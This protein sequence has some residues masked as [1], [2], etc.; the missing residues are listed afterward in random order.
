KVKGL[1]PCGSL[2]EN[3]RRIVRVRLEEVLALGEKALDPSDEKALHDTRIAAKRL[4]YVLE[5]HVPVFGEPAGAAAKEARRL[6]DL[7]GEIHDCDELLPRVQ[8]VQRELR[9]GDVDGLLDL[10]ADADDLDP[11][12]GAKVRH[13]DAYGGLEVLAVW[14]E[15]RRT[16][17]FERFL[18]RWK[19]LQR[20]AFRERLE[21][22]LDDRV[23]VTESLPPSADGQVQSRVTA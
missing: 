20:Q 1:D 3:A 21:R 15:A 19:T 12:L 9:D 10:G 5:M 11:A 22:A 16:L 17:L 14:L 7:L 2:E 6:Q 4:R 18:D 23:S 8:A 13:A